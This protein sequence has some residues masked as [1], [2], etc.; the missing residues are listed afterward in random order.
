[1]RPTENTYSQQRV[2]NQANQCWN[3]NH[4]AFTTS[5]ELTT[6]LYAHMHTTPC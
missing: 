1:M 6:L 2:T 3:I 5:A 4:Y